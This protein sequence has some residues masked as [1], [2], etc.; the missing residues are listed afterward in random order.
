[1]TEMHANEFQANTDLT[2]CEAEEAP[3]LRVSVTWQEI[4]PAL[5]IDEFP[6]PA[7]E[8][9]ELLCAEEDQRGHL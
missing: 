5:S 9:K 8:V 7:S 4:E 2:E 1:M 6:R 3:G